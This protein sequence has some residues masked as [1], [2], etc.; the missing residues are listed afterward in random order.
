M[1]NPDSPSSS[2]DTRGPEVTPDRSGPIGQS[3][4]QE[5]WRKHRRET[6]EA[7]EEWERACEAMPT[8]DLERSAISLAKKVDTYR[9]AT[10]SEKYPHLQAKRAEILST[11]E[12]RLEIAREVLVSKTGLTAMEVADLVAEESRLVD[13]VRFSNNEQHASDVRN[14][15]ER[16]N[17]ASDQL[18]SFRN[19]LELVRIVLAHKRAGR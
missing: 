2:A 19:Q 5:A 14:N 4:S 17:Q 18:Y 1:R 13:M 15:V 9:G 8:V 12:A 11:S 6:R 16:R 10:P 3:E 7:L